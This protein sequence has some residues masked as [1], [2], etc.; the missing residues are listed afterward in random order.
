MYKIDSDGHV[1]NEFAD[2]NPQTATKATIIPAAWLNAVMYELVNVVE[3]AGLTPNKLDSAQ[4][5]AALA[6]LAGP[7]WI[8]AP[9]GMRRKPG[10]TDTFTIQPFGCDING[11]PCGLAAALDL[12]PTVAVDNIYHLAVEVPSG[13]LALTAD[14]F[15]VIANGN[16]VPAYSPTL[17]YWYMA[18]GGVGQRCLGWLLT[19][20]S[21]EIIDFVQRNGVWRYPDAVDGKELEAG[22]PATSWALL[23]LTAPTA[24]GELRALLRGVISGED[25]HVK[26]GNSSEAISTDLNR[27]VQG[28]VRPEEEFMVQADDSAQVYYATSAGTHTLKVYTRE[29]VLPPR[30]LGGKQ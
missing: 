8:F 5:L 6:K 28:A 11:S 1:D 10:T 25:L 26:D 30:L 22:S 12:T 29:I 2:G 19:N 7:G 20:G 9:G 14:D 18:G 23:T 13:G 16:D 24:Y 27:R 21:G 17:D 15:S 4:L 3:K